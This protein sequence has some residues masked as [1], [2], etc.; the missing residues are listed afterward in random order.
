SSPHQG[1]RDAGTQR[2]APPVPGLPLALPC[3]P[4]S[5]RPCVPASLRPRVPASPRPCVPA[6]PRPCVSAA[7][8]RSVRPDR[9][10][11]DNPGSTGS[12]L[13]SPVPPG[14][15]TLLEELI[16]DSSPEAR[17]ACEVKMVDHLEVMQHFAVKIVDHLEVR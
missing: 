11:R 1:A 2:S 6:S 16:E 8:C 3:V 7:L 14:A 17:K 9:P 10:E 13:P 4:A 5:P 15:I 12:R